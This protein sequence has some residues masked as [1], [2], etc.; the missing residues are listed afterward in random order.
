MAK[1]KENLKTIIRLYFLSSIFSCQIFI[2]RHYFIQNF[3]D[4]IQIRASKIYIERENYF[5]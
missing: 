4:R 1:S 3:K 2:L 5:S